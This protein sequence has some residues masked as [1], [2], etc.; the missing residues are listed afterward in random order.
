MKEQSSWFYTI[1]VTSA[2]PWLKSSE[3]HDEVWYCEHAAVGAGSGKCKTMG[4]GG[5]RQFL[6]LQQYGRALSDMLIQEEEY[7]ILG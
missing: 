2:W 6:M 5:K 7:W 3:D 1:E 4:R